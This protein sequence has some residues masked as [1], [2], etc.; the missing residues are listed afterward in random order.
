MSFILP[1]I[2]GAASL[3]KAIR[4]ASDAEG[5][6]S[7]PSIRVTSSQPSRPGGVGTDA[8][9]GSFAEK[10]RTRLAKE[11][12]S[13]GDGLISRD[14]L[15]QQLT[16]GGASA[17]AIDQKFQAM[18]KNGDGKVSVDELKN[19]NALPVSPVVQHVLQ[20]IDARHAAAGTRPS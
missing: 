17:A 12:D 15:A 13:N 1:I 8:A 14:E 7:G 3:F 11:A 16:K 9:S 6:A 19:A 20:M 18:D 5:A 2:S 4:G 10:F